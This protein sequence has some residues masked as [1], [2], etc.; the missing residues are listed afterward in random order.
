MFRA[1][2]TQLDIDIERILFHPDRNRTWA[3]IDN[4]TIVYTI[5]TDRIKQP[6]VGAMAPRVGASAMGYE[7]LT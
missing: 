5:K 1:D 3:S 6:R 4:I 2:A 7:W